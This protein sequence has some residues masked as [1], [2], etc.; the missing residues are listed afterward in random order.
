VMKRLS[1]EMKSEILRLYAA[2]CPVLSIASQ[3]MVDES[4]P[5]VLASRNNV[6]LRAGAM[7]R[8]NMGIAKRIRPNERH[9]RNNAIL[10]LWKAGMRSSEIDERLGMTSPR[11]VQIVKQARGNGDKR[12]VRRWGRA[13]L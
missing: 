9:K 5:S 3:F 4:Y 2:G 13:N 7:A 10:D 6:K 1:E 12:A 8:E 11:V